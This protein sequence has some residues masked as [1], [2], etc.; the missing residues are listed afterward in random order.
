MFPPENDTKI[1]FGKYGPQYLN[2][3]PGKILYRLSCRRF[4][5]EPFNANGPSGRF[6]HQ[7]QR[8]DKDGINIYWVSKESFDGNGKPMTHIPYDRKTCYLGEN[9]RTC[10]AESFMRDPE[11]DYHGQIND[12]KVL[13]TLSVVRSLTLLDLRSPNERQLGIPQKFFDEQTVCVDYDAHQAWARRIYEDPMLEFKPIDGII[14]QSTRDSSQRCYVLNER[15]VNKIQVTQSTE[16]SYI[17]S[18]VESIAAL[19]RLEIGF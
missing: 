10:I 11:G 14:W 4:V 13:V 15:A 17:R 5:N 3:I 6:D 12:T 1:A 18:H 9:L 16:L 2:L 8:F 7:L 19:Y